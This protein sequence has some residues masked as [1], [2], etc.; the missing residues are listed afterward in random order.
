[1]ISYTIVY[2][3]TLYFGIPGVE[4]SLGLLVLPDLKSPLADQNTV[5]FQS[6][7]HPLWLWYAWRNFGFV[8]LPRGLWQVQIFIMCGSVLSHSI[9]IYSKI[10]GGSKPLGQKLDINGY[11]SRKILYIVKCHV[12][13]TSP[14]PVTRAKFR[15]VRYPPWSVTDELIETLQYFQSHLGSGEFNC[16][17]IIQKFRIQCTYYVICEVLTSWNLQFGMPVVSVC[18]I[19]LHLTKK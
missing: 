12:Q 6:N 4:L 13:R 3:W 1:M 14:W 17:Y 10:S 16:K 11:K 8:T 18:V 15:H 2:N 19:E 7:W 5:G 9:N